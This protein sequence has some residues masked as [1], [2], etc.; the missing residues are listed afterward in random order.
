MKKLLILLSIL[1]LIICDK[2]F[3]EKFDNKRRETRI[4]RRNYRCMRAC[5]A[6]YRITSNCGCRKICEYG[7]DYSKGKCKKGNPK[8]NKCSKGHYYSMEHKRC[9]L[10]NSRTCRKNG[11]PI[12]KPEIKPK[13]IDN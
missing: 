7:Y 10:I 11:G 12:R 3:N 5:H 6:G 9:C 2:K 1:L 8:P 4:N 13:K